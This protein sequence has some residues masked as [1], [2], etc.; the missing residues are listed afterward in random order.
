MRFFFLQLFRKY[1][2]EN[3]RAKGFEQIVFGLE[4]A[5]KCGTADISAVYDLLDRDLCIVLFF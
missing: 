3:I 4:M 2:A 1:M 5:V